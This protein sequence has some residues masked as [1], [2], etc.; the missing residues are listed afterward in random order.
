MLQ[1]KYVIVVGVDYSAA[2]ER[3]LD[4]AFALGRSKY[5][6]QL[7]V[8]NVRPAPSDP[9]ATDEASALPPWRYWAIEL[10][11]YVARKVA[12]FRAT[13]GATPFQH[14][15]TEQRIGEPVHELTQLATSVKAD[16]LVLG[17]HDWQNPSSATANSIAEAVTRLAR[18]PVLVVHRNGST[19]SEPS[20]VHTRSEPS[21]VSAD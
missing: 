10:Q 14:L 4:E 17:T 21:E 8:V 5:G 16:L 15:Y 6:V 18:C 7:H 3:A 9:T 19:R 20:N 11:E 13:A 1:S 2:S 12:S